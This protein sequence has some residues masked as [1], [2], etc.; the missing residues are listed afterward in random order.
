MNDK[1]EF[2]AEQ[3]AKAFEWLRAAALDGN[4][5][6]AAMLVEVDDLNQ[7]IAKLDKVRG[8]VTVLW[9]LVDAMVKILTAS[10]IYNVIEQ[11]PNDHNPVVAWLG[12]ARA[13]L[14]VP[15]N[16]DPA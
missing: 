11:N 7:R 9:N 12:R 3:K 10:G 13:Q 16:V 4:V 14:V 8:R 2:T 15:A 1:P 6:A 5:H